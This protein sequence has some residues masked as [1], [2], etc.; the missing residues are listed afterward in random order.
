MLAALKRVFAELSAGA[1]RGGIAED[2][3]RLAAVALLVHVAS[4][5]GVTAEAERAQLIDLVIGRFGVDPAKARALLV[6]AERRDR[7]A[8]D[9]YAF[10]SL[11]KLKLDEAGRLEIVDMMWEVAFADGKLHEFEENVIWRVAELLGVPARD[12]L[13]ARK[14][15]ARAHA[16]DA[17]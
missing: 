16:G 8:V 9:L 15:A 13:T 11:L 5:D 7:E 3:R 17:S 2:E 1:P 6:A 4:I 14:R 10:T 12:R